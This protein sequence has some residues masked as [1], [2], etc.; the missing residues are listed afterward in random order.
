MK[1]RNRN[2][3]TER[4]GLLAV[5]HACNR[6]DLIWRDL[7]QED[8]GIDGTIEVAIGE[9]PTGKLVGAQV[10]S[11]TSYIRGETSDSFRFYPDA[12]DIQYWAGVSIPMFLLVHD[13]RS[14]TVYWADIGRYVQER[15]EDP[16]GPSTINIAKS[17]VLDDEFAKYL[18]A[19]FDLVLYSGEQYASASTEFQALS[20]TFGTGESAVTITALD[21]FIEG[22]WGLCSKIQFHSSLMSELIRRSAARRREVLLFTYAFDRASL[23]P[24]LTRYFNLL[25]RHHVAVLDSSDINQSLYGK[26]EFPTFIA[27]LTTNGRRFTE[28]LRA[29]GVPRVHDNQHLTLALLPHVQIEVYSSFCVNDGCPV[30]GEFTDV[31]GISFNSHLDYYRIEHWRRASGEE[32]RKA[33]EQNAFL[34]EVREYLIHHFE[35][36]PKDCLLFRYKDAPLAPLICWLEDWNDNRQPI[37]GADLEGKSNA[38]TAG[39]HD[40]LMAIMAPAGVMTVTE[41][42]LPPFPIPL[43]ANGDL[44]Y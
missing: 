38:E 42:K 41:P 6:L 10:K 23:Y 22:L 26:L 18:R 17:S 39:F 24:F 43:L 44:L 16:L 4:E 28:Y 9:F 11:G 35:K 12:D 40:E 29:S 2:A 15:P 20:H 5:E 31:L 37:A 30:F 19:R 34:S 3:I 25:S 33:W 32:A 7:L 8:V 27:P 21:L 14:G 1:K 36:V 13:P